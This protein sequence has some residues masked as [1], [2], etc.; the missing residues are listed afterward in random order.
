MECQHQS[1]TSHTGSNLITNVNHLE[2]FQ[3]NK[4]EDH[5]WKKA[6]QE[7]NLSWLTHD[8][9]HMMCSFFCLLAKKS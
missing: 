9:F 3:E 2:E 4:I 1:Y 7:L 8:L 6:C 5:S